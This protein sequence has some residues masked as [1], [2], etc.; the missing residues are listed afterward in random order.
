MKDEVRESLDENFDK[1]DKSEMRKNLGY[2]SPHFKATIMSE[3]TGTL[4]RMVL[5]NNED[6]HKVLMKIAAFS[7]LW[8]E[9]DNE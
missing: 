1:L 6:Y 3:L 2:G 9:I 5:D 7:I 8:Y 4:A